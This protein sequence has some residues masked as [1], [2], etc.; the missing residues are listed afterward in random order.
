MNIPHYRN[1]SHYDY[2]LSGILPVVIVVMLAVIASG[3]ESEGNLTDGPHSVRGMRLC[4]SACD[5]PTRARR[6]RN[7]ADVADRRMRIIYRLTIFGWVH[8]IRMAF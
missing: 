4:L 7:T 3:C 5:M 1:F 6:V 8:L 2:I